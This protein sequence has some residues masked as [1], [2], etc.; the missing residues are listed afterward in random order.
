M[1]TIFGCEAD[2][3]L[4]GEKAMDR[5]ATA[6]EKWSNPHLVT[7]ITASSLTTR[8]VTLL[9]GLPME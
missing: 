2:E 9:N 7:Y 5:P 1:Y 6:A 8:G 4:H 3:I